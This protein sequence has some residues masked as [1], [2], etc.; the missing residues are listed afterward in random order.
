MSKN[1]SEEEKMRYIEEFKKSGLSINKYAKENDIPRATLYRWI[2]E[3]E[4][5]GFGEIKEIQPNVDIPRLT[6]KKSVFENETVRIELKERF[7]KDFVLK[8]VEV[9]VNA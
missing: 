8:I 7:D 1:C 2:K 5:F 9:M 3:D 4:E 6:N